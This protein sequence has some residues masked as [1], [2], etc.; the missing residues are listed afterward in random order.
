[1]Q[2]KERKKERTKWE[3]DLAR[4][5]FRDV[6]GDTMKGGL[7]SRVKKIN[8]STLFG[9]NGFVFYRRHNF[10]GSF[11]MKNGIALSNC[12]VVPYN[13]ELLIHYNAHVNVEICCQSMLIKYLFKN[14]SKEFDRVKEP[15]RFK[16]ILIAYLFVLMKLFGDSCNFLSIQG[17]Q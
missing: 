3:V 7:L 11:V 2:V 8:E 9:E 1:M 14:V 10:P 5:V 6:H 15:M 12:Y 13:K 16:L 4:R 17:T